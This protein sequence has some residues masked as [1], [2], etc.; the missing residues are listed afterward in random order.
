MDLQGR[1]CCLPCKSFSS[2]EQPRLGDTTS[3]AMQLFAFSLTSL[4]LGHRKL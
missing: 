1:R 3:Q 2:S 4:L